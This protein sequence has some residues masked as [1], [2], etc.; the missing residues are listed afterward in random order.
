MCY[1]TFI[2]DVK[3]PEELASVLAET[4]AAR[5]L[6]RHIARMDNG[7]LSEVNV[8]AG[9]RKPPESR[10]AGWLEWALNYQGDSGSKLFVGMIQRHPGAD[11]EFHS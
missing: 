4:E 11:F 9:P 3:T 10:E 5:A 6:T 7:H 2:V 1:I 8:Y